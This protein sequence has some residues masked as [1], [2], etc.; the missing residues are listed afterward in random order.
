MQR[1]VNSGGSGVRLDIDSGGADSA[2]R[3]FAPYQ[4]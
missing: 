3:D 4:E 1:A 2:D